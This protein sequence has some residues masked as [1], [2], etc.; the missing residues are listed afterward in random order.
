MKAAREQSFRQT[1]LTN[2]FYINMNKKLK[3]FVYNLLGFIPFYII[4]Y[5]L[6]IK[7]TGVTG[8]WVPVIAAVTTTILAPKFQTVSYQG[9]E[10][11]FM[12]WL[13]FK[14][15]KEVK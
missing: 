14:D 10:R 9:Q 11:I 7:F 3:A 12:K 15:V 13:F 5:A 6:L 2:K 4:T 8:L 1:S